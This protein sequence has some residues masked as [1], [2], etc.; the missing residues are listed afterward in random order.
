MVLIQSTL[1]AIF[2]GLLTCSGA[3][4]QQWPNKPVRIINPFSPGG[5]LD[6]VSRLLARGMSTDLGQQFVVE[7]HA[8][9]GG[10][11]DV[12]L[13]AKLPLDGYTLLMVQS[14]QTVNPGM[15]RKAPYDPVR[16]FE[17]T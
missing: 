8:G 5:S 7:N 12:G 9:A 15:Q 1:V 2:I 13:V 17:P 3:N 6:L 14:S 4:A 11:I 16:N 10:S